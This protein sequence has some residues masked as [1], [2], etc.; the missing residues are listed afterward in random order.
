MATE[1]KPKEET[2]ES[3]GNPPAKVATSEEKKVT[4]PKTYS[5]ADYLKAVSDQK[6]IAGRLQKQVEDLTKERDNLRVESEEAKA[7]VEETKSKLTELEGDLETLTEDNA[8]AAEIAKMKKRIQATEDQLKKDL[9]TKQDAADAEKEA[10]RKDREEWAG[11][12]NEAREMR[13]WQNALEV[14]EEYEGGDKDKLKSLCDDRIEVTGKPMSR[15]DVDKL[16]SRL[17]AKKAKP[18]AEDEPSILNDSGVNNGGR[19]KDTRTMSPQ[20]KMA[21]QRRREKNKIQVGGN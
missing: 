7:S 11:E 15:E 1:T 4:P 14:S 17:W 2:P 20:Q 21:E 6:T 9:K 18:E 12:V 16:A 13:L 3:Q 5:E 10:A 8:P 19:G